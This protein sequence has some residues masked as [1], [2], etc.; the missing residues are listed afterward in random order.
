MSE[1]MN[2]WV[3]AEVA[4][5]GSGPAEQAA[6]T[7][8]TQ[9]PLHHVNFAELSH[10]RTQRLTGES[11][12]V[13][14]KEMPLQG[15]LCLRGDPDQISLADAVSSV[16]GL[17]LPQPL[18]SDERDARCLRWMAPDEWWLSCGIAEAFELESRLREAL[19]GHYAIVNISAGFTTL[20]LAGEASRSV[21][22]KSTGYDVHPR[23]F[24]PGKV[25]RTLFGKTGVALRCLDDARYEIIVRRSFADYLWLWLQAASQE[26]GLRVEA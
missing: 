7:V 14:L 19:S 4:G 16:T 13:V 12:R 21:L 11:A 15:L 24:P 17:S 23:N 25:V 6:Q 3:A 8:S 1:T 10:H 2:Q 20:L 18:Q 26:Y 9:T 5:D 22:M